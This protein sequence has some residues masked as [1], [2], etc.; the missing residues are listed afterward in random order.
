MSTATQ[1]PTMTLAEPAQALIDARLDTIER[2]LLGQVPRADRLAI[3]REVE[4]QIHDH[5]AERNPDDTDRDAV[6]AALARLDPPEA[7]LPDEDGQVTHPITA[8]RV[9]PGSAVARPAPN[10]SRPVAGTRVGLVAGIVGMFGLFC[11]LALGLMFYLA[12]LTK[13]DVGTFGVYALV[14]LNALTLLAGA[15]AVI[16]AAMARLGGAWAI[17]GLTLGLVCLL[18]GMIFGSLLLIE[19]LG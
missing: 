4:A 1:D 14:I 16:F 10:P 13:I 11:L 7:Y 9:R 17:A 18:P 6:I 15:Q 2:M 12:F 3:V 8:P 19:L 5:L